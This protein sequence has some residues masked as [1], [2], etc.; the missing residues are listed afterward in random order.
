MKDMNKW[1]KG[2]VMAIFE[3]NPG[4]VLSREALMGEINRMA[5][6]DEDWNS[7]GAYDQYNHLATGLNGLVRKKYLSYKRVGGKSQYKACP[8]PWKPKSKTIIEEPAE[9]LSS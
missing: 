1:I 4:F 6:N 7:I 2:I 8:S 3:A 9:T 5:T